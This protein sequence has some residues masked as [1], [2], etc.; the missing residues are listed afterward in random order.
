MDCIG[1][2]KKLRTDFEFHCKELTLKISFNYVD[3]RHSSPSAGRKGEKRGKSS[4]TKRMLGERDAQ[5]DAEEDASSERSIWRSVYNMMRYD[6][7]TCP[8]GPHCWVD[9]MGKKHYSLKTHHLKRLIAHVEKDG[10][11]EG[12]N[13][14]PEV[15]RNELYKEEEERRKGDKQKGDHSNRAE[16]PYPPFSNIINVLPSQ[17]APNGSDGSAPKAV[18]DQL[19]MCPLEIPGP[20]DVAVEEY[21]EWQMSNFTNDALKSAFRQVCDVMLD[22]GL[23]LEQVYKDQD[24]NFFI[25]KGIKIGIARRFVEDIGKWAEKVKKVMPVYEVL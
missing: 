4:V 24:P 21:G 22:H 25:E 16:V 7:L 6:S 8:H 5:L 19:T 20:R 2:Y 15:V 9:P 17:A 12:H 11:L 23:D 3:D 1:F 13:D 10:I 14:V 18:I